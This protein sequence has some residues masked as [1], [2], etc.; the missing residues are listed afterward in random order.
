MTRTE[1]IEI[2][3]ADRLESVNLRIDLAVV[4]T[5]QLLHRVVTQRI[6]LHVLFCGFALRV[7]VDGSRGRKNK[8]GHIVPT[9]CFE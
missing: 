2:T 8:A 3:Q 7:A 1:D 9:R 5:G 6:R 4:F